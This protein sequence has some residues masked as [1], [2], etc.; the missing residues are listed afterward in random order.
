MFSRHPGRQMDFDLSL[1]THN[2][3]PSLYRFT[4]TGIAI[5]E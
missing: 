3:A 2:N 5:I 4:K 1:G